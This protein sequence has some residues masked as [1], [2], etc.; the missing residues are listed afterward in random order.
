VSTF[1]CSLLTIS[2]GSN[3][4]LAAGGEAMPFGEKGI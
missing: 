1:S 3:T 4:P 2:P